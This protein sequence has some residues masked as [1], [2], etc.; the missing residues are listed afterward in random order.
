[1][2]KPF[3]N[4]KITREICLDPPRTVTKLEKGLEPSTY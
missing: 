1:M 3:M 2:N 4:K